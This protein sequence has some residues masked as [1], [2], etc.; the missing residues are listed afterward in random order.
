MLSGAAH[1]HG[2]V[3]ACVLGLPAGHQPQQFPLPC[4]DLH[5]L[6]QLRPVLGGC[7][8]VLHCLHDAFS[9]QKR[10]RC[11][12]IPDA[13]DG[14]RR[15]PRRPLPFR[16]GVKVGNV[17][18]RF[19]DLLFRVSLRH[20]FR[21]GVLFLRCHRIV[22]GA[23]AQRSSI[24]H[25]A[26]SHSDKVHQRSVFRVGVHPLVQ[27]VKVAELVGCFQ[28]FGVVAHRLRTHRIHALA[29]APACLRP[30]VCRRLHCAPHRRRR[31]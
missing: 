22:A 28:L 31:G 5:A 9:R 26:L 29:A 23:A 30:L 7:G 10:R 14:I 2:V 17:L 21:V 25:A 4:V 27:P 1:L 11:H 16:Q 15:S 20:Q 12:R 24:F 19:A 13:A 6:L 8:L 18:P 3:P